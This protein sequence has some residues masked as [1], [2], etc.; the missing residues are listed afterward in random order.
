MDFANS[1]AEAPVGEILHR[2]SQRRVPVMLVCNRAPSGSQIHDELCDISVGADK[3]LCALTA[4]L[5]YSYAHRIRGL[6]YVLLPCLHN[7]PLNGWC[8][9]S[10]GDEGLDGRSLSFS[11]PEPEFL[12]PDPDFVLSQGY[13]AERTAFASAPAWEERVDTLYWRGA[14]SGV[15]RYSNPE[16][17]PR[18]AICRL[19][20]AHPGLI[21]A[22]ITRIERRTNWEGNRAY[23]IARGYLRPAE[24]QSQILRY[25]YQIDI[26][27]N[28]NAWAGLFLKLLSGSPVLKVTSEF[29]FR[30]WYYQDLKPWENFVPVRPD[31]ADLPEALSRLRAHPADARRIGANGA[32]LARSMTLATELPKAFRAVGQLIAL[33]QHAPA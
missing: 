19:S 17:A 7:A 29:G 16:D 25:R 12:V 18:L 3:V 13:E 9:A 15:G 26:D 8:A 22:A 27:G 4:G 20:Q 21:D 23:Y 30:Q 28:S 6:L 10:L 1:R 24:E 11:F 31:L 2:P 33:N 32:A 14:D 5:P